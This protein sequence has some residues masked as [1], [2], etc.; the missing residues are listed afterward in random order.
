MYPYANVL[1]C[2]KVCHTALMEKENLKVLLQPYIGPHTIPK[3]HTFISN[4]CGSFLKSARVILGG[5]D[6]SQCTKAEDLLVSPRRTSAK[7][8]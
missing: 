8:N 5:V 3:I 1:T 2:H 4:Y 7:Q 6:P